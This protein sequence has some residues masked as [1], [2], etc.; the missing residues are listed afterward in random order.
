MTDI[1]LSAS[2]RRLLADVTA[3]HASKQREPQVEYIAT[4]Y[5]QMPATTWASYQAMTHLPE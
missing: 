1:I 5:G 3:I 2:E 4:V